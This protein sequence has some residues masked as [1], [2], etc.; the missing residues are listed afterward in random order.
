MPATFSRHHA[1]SSGAQ[2]WR[3]DTRRS[4]RVTHRKRALVVADSDQCNQTM[5]EGRGG[6]GTGG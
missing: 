3:I 2:P 5:E 6:G 4:S 1:T